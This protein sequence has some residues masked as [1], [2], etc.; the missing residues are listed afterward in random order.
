MTPFHAACA[1]GHIAI[2]EMLLLHNVDR[3]IFDS[4]DDQQSTPLHLAAH[5][6]HLNVCEMLLQRF[7]GDTMVI[8]Y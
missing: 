6:G 3:S 5:N 4:K 8:R 2:V 1:H 7:A